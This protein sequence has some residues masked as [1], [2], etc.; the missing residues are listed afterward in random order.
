MIT[1]LWLTIFIIALTRQSMEQT[2]F[3]LYYVA[4]YNR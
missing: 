2:N 3:L 1:D 4:R